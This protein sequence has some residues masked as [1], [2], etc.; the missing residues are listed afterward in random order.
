[1]PEAAARLHQPAPPDA[2]MGEFDTLVGLVARL[3]GPGG[4]PWDAEQTHQSLKRHLLEEAYEAL[5]AIDADDLP[6]L[7]GELGDLLL[8][9]AFH[10]D[11]AAGNGDFRWDE[12]LR[13]LN[14]KLVRRHPHVFGGAAAADA[15]EVE[16]NW[17]RIKAEERRAAADDGSAAAAPPSPVDGLPAALPALAYAQLMQERVARAAGFDWEDL[18]GVLDKVEEEIGEFR[19]AANDQERQDELGDLLFAVVNLC[20][21][22]GVHAEDA[23][24]QSSARFRRRYRTM[25][26]LAEAQGQNFAALPL[27]E[28]ETLWQQAKR[29]QPPAAPG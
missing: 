13:R 15:R 24:R 22:N 6:A 17:E 10:A 28:K 9:I 12:V 16:R 25:T 20:R 5:E 11:I 27:P 26:A 2:A 1:M 19:R 23:L 29:Q 18:G 8:Q 4:C 3:R 21:W 14:E 7:A